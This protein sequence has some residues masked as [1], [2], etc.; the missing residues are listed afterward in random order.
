MF[1]FA[2]EPAPV[3][4]LGD[5]RGFVSGEA[6]RSGVDRLPHTVAEGKEGE[7]TV[8]SLSTVAVV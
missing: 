2:Q 7:I 5:D 1:L 8:N 3:P 4:H 6:I